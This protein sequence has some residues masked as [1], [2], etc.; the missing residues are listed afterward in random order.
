VTV[1][2][3]H[4]LVDA[5]DA[6][7]KPFETT[8]AFVQAL[9]AGEASAAAVMK[10]VSSELGVLILHAINL[11]EPGRLVIETDVP[12]LGA[13]VIEQL[14]ESRAHLMPRRNGD[15]EQTE[16]RLSDLGEFGGV[17]GAA[18]PTLRRFFRLP[19]WS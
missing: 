1:P 17:R 3:V 6:A 14:R 11:F 19:S 7:G 18:V 16:V 2:I 9:L 10:R 15:T 12:E 13:A 5:R 4:P 8:A